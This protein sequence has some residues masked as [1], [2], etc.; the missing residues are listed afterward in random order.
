MSIAKKNEVIRNSFY[1]PED[2]YTVEQVKNIRRNSV[3]IPELDNDIKDK[4][5]DAVDYIYSKKNS[6]TAK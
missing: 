4:I 3:L 1:L 2:E 5:D 6:K